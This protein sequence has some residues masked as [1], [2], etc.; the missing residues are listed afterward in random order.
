MKIEKSRTIC[1]RKVLLI[2]MFFPSGLP[3]DQLMILT[4]FRFKPYV[5]N[6]LTTQQQ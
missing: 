6:S 2:K 4:T 5:K 3:K 1:I